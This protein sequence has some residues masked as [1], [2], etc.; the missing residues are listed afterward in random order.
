MLNTPEYLIVHHTGGTQENPLAD[1]SH[2]TYEIVH[3]YHLS[4]GWEGFG[5]H[6]F[7]AKDGALKAGRAE[8]Y[9]GAH[10][11]NYNQKSIGICL[12]GNFDATMPT[13]AQESSLQALLEMLSKKY[14]IPNE[15]IVPHRRF[16][17][18][19]CYG[20]LLA[21]DWAARLVPVETRHAQILAALD[22][23]KDLVNKLYN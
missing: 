12:A 20:K 18:K 19:T 15:N 4:L 5:Y 1:T 8:N 6:Y 3:N 13:K 11:K 17:P 16:A 21:D 2:H 10:T 22:G 14:N 7:I 9:H 23:V